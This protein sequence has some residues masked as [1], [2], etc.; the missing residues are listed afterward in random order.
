MK[1][2]I[3][4]VM[5]SFGIGNAKDA[6]SF[7]DLGADTFGNIAKN[8]SLDIPN[9]TSLGLVKSYKINNSRTVDF[10]NTKTKVLGGTFYG[11][12]QEVS[13]G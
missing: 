6:A 2:V 13:V 11:A 8:Y 12:A 10:E 3:W 7:G 9:L 4:L 5:D 1:R